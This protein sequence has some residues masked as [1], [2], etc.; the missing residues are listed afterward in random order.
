V[1]SMNR[2]SNRGAINGLISLRV[3]SG[4]VIPGAD[5][6]QNVIAN[7]RN[8]ADNTTVM[9]VDRSTSSRSGISLLNVVRTDL[10]FVEV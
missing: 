2:V 5:H 6:A 9:I 4:V 1:T 7:A 10:E 8:M 3:V